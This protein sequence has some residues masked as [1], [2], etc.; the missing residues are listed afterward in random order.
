[1]A[2]PRSLNI[3]EESTVIISGWLEKKSPSGMVKSWKKR[4]FVITEDQL[5]AQ[6]M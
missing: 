6:M 4:W 5:D 2:A 3:E 1:M